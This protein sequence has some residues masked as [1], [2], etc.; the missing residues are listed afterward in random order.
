MQQNGIGRNNLAIA[1]NNYIIDLHVVD[2]H[3]FFVSVNN[4]RY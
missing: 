1:N 4:S 2:V 3:E